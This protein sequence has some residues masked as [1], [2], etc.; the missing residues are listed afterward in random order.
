[1]SSPHVALLMD[2]FS[3]NKKYSV[4]LKKAIGPQHIALVDWAIQDLSS[5]VN[6]ERMILILK[7]YYGIEY[8][9]TSLAQIGRELERPVTAPRVRAAR[10]RALQSM[11][12]NPKLQSVAAKLKRCG[13]DSSEMDK[14]LSLPSAELIQSLQGLVE[15]NKRFEGTFLLDCFPGCT[16]AEPCPTCR[17]LEL[18]R[19]HG[20]ELSLQTL[21]HEWQAGPPSDWRSVPVQA[22]KFSA[23]VSKALKNESVVT[24]GGLVKNTASQLLCFPYFGPKSLKEV[25]ERLAELGLNLADEKVP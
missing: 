25:Q 3:I 22:L 6:G 8:E 4:A 24:L 23:Q 17:G 10:E 9:K 11:C 5:K 19:R 1:M 14:N 21:A 18:L 20:L 7:Q 12:V 15:A 16:K 2:M 13:I